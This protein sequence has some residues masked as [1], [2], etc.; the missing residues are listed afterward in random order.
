MFLT[1]CTILNYFYALSDKSFYWPLTPFQRDKHTPSA[2][3]NTCYKQIAIIQHPFITFCY[4]RFGKHFRTDRYY[5]F[6]IKFFIILY[7]CYNIRQN[8]YKAIVRMS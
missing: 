5:N 8:K 1:V 3:L 7:I 2:M 4:C 6:V